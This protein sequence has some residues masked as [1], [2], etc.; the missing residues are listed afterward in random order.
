EDQ[1]KWIMELDT[2]LGQY[3]SDRT[4]KITA[5]LKKY[6]ALLEDVSY[7]MP[8]DIHRLID[9]EAMMMNQAILANRRAVARLVLQATEKHLQKGLLLR[10]HWEDKVQDWTRLKVQASVDRFREFMSD[11]LI[12]EPRGVQGTLESMRA[13]QEHLSQKLQTELSLVPPRCSKELVSEWHS[14]LSALHEQIGDEKH[15]GCF[16]AL[17]S[18]KHSGC[19]DAA[20]QAAFECLARRAAAVSQSL[21]RFMRGAAEL[22]EVHTARLQRADRQLK[23]Q[24]EEVRQAHQRENQV[25]RLF[26]HVHQCE[27]WSSLESSHARHHQDLAI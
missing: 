10:L 8:P 16:A 14:S 15:S 26:S 11:P 5:V 4:T 23:V 7:M 20:P 13:K 27:N 21:F 22:W 24:L 6:S 19:F 18:D 17:C 12:Q 25:R 9:G 3:E 1:K 2:V